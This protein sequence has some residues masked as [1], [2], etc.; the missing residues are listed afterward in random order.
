[1]LEVGEEVVSGWWNDEDVE[2]KENPTWWPGVI[3]SVTVKREQDYGF[4]PARFYNIEYND[5]D[6]LNDVHEV[7]VFPKYEFDVIRNIDIE[8]LVGIEKVC[9]ENSKDHWARIG[10]YNVSVDDGAT[11]SYFWLGDALE[12]Y[13]RL[14]KKPERHDIH[15]D[16]YD[17]SSDEDDAS[18]ADSCKDLSSGLLCPRCNKHFSTKSGL[19]YHLSEYLLQTLLLSIC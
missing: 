2:R 12:A 15:N 14:P 19:A 1:M 8:D 11:E 10:W 16:A 9:D 13:K 5:G 3:T 17:A 6:V 18:Y 7:F 4:G